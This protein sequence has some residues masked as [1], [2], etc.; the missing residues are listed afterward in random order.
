MSRLIVT[1]HVSDALNALSER[2]GNRVAVNRA[3]ADGARVLIQDHFIDQGGKNRNPY[4]KKP[5]FWAKMFRGTRSEADDNHGYVS[6][7]R[8]IALRFFGAIVR[9]FLSKFLAIPARAEAYG[10]SPRE[11]FNL[12]FVKF[13]SGA[14]ALVEAEATEI[15]K[16]KKGFR[17]GREA[18][19]LVM[20]WLAESATI[21]KDPDVLPTEVQI[22]KSALA[23]LT[24]YALRRRT[25]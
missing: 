25:V 23:A 24:E 15:R 10:K 1:D 16:A 3:M 12:R 11:F 5:T 7:P 17:P 9:A 20:F 19:G 2:I 22:A 8:E 18:G 21:H 14:R 4:G 13:A 6:M